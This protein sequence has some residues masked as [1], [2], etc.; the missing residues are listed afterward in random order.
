MFS[1]VRH[2]A[3]RNSSCPMQVAVAYVI[4]LASAGT[5]YLLVARMQFSSIITVAAMAQCLSVVFLAMQSFATRGKAQIGISASS[6]VFQILGLACRLSATMNYNGYLPVDASGDWLYQATDGTTLVLCLVLLTTA[7]FTRTAH[8]EALAELACVAP[9]ALGCFALGALLHADT[10]QA[11]LYDTAWM[12]GVFLL[13]AAVISQFL[14]SNAVKGEPN[15]RDALAALLCSHSILAMAMAQLLGALFIWHARS[16]MTCEEIFEGFN[17]AVWAVLA[18]HVIPLVMICDFSLD[19]T[20]EN[21][22]D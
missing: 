12:A 21:V 4:F 22:E 10:D 8:A 9:V 15:S 5:V 7:L 1:A 13:S 19:Y 14:K 11:P 16:D 18:A 20:T 6:L 2:G 17:H 3:P